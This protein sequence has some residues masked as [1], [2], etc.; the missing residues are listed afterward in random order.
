MK[1]NSTNLS[2]FLRTMTSLL[3]HLPRNSYLHI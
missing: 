3:F 1:N 2:L